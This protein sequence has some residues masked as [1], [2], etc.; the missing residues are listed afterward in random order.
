MINQRLASAQ[1]LIRQNPPLIWYTKSYDQLSIESIAEAIFNY[2]TWQEFLQLK[3][4]LGLQN[5][6]Q[7]FAKLDNMPRNNLL[8]IYRNYF[9]HYFHHYA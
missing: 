7:I 8:S 9:R 1:N 6:A 4:I 5:L 2:G 3:E